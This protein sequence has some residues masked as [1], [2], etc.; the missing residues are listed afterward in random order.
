MS[1]TNRQRN[2]DSN[3]PLRAVRLPGLVITESIA[4]SAIKVSLVVGTALN[5]INNGPQWLSG[6]AISVWKIALNYLVPFLVSSYSGARNEAQGNGA[7]PRPGS[8]VERASTMPR[9]WSCRGDRSPRLPALWQHIQAPSASANAEKSATSIS[10]A[11]A[12]GKICCPGR[13]MNAACSPAHFAP[14]TSHPCAATS[15]QSAGAA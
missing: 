1:L 6:D 8:D 4:V 15:M 9:G 2:P 10:G 14:A 5:A 7:R 11:S 3:R 12:S 13:A